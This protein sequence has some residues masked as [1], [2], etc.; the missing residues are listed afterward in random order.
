MTFP[1]GLTKPTRRGKESPSLIWKCLTLILEANAPD[2]FIPIDALP[3]SSG[4]A[5][6]PLD[7]EFR[8]KRI[9]L[10]TMLVPP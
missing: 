6:M 9:H 7:R 4:F 1:H 5:I 3:Y 2:I 8:I 10:Y